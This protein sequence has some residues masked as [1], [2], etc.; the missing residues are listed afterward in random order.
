MKIPIIFISIIVLVA[1]SGCSKQERLVAERASRVLE[2]RLEQRVMALTEE[3]KAVE[4]KRSNSFVELVNDVCDKIEKDD[5][6]YDLTRDI[7][8][9]DYSRKKSN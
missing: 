2:N 8:P 3:G 6:F 9:K 4:R 7:D 5:E 1:T